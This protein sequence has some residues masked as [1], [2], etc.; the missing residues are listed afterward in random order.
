MISNKRLNDADIIIEGCILIWNIGLPLLKKSTRTHIYKPFQSAAS[1]LES[2]QSNDNILR[3]CL[4][5]ELAKY[6]IEQDFLSKASLQL[7]R[8]LDV[9]YSLTLKQIPGDLKEDDDSGDF[10]RPYQKVLKFLLKKLSLKTNLYG[11]DPDNIQDQIV[12]DV[13]N[14]KTTKNQ[15]MRETLL[16]KAL[17]DLQEFDEPE[18]EI[19]PEANLVEEE[20]KVE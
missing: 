14:A 3:V 9:D 18:F 10:Q 11:G 1:A 6:E 4:H 12:L 5:L 7:K 17:K 15:K 8:A 19:D 13:E 16:E 2:I 20:I